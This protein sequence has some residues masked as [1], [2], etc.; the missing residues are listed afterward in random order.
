MWPQS[1]LQSIQEYIRHSRSVQAL[2]HLSNRKPASRL[3]QVPAGFILSHL[4]VLL[5]IQTFNHYSFI[6]TIF[7]EKRN[8]RFTG[9]FDFL[10]FIRQ[11]SKICSITNYRIVITFRIYEKCTWLFCKRP[12]ASPLIN[13]TNFISCSFNHIMLYYLHLLYI[14]D[15]SHSHS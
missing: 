11:E 4:T 7:K 13:S 15:Y 6:L 12:S 14:G 5:Q 3:Y 9:E 8:I 2:L 10:L 1:D